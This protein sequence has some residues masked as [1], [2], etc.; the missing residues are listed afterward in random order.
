MKF[1]ATIAILFFAAQSVISR[2]AEIIII[3]HGEKPDEPKAQ[4]LSSQGEERAKALVGFFTKNSRA[5]EHGLPVA[6]FA[7]DPT[8][9][10]SGQRPRET[11]QPVARELHLSIQTPF[12]SKDYAK[13]AQLILKSS[14]YDGKTV[15]I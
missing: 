4:H 3:R 2:P 8:H 7:S 9:K 5:T 14:K 12:E 11:L 15:V 1:L 13:L 6:L 10:G